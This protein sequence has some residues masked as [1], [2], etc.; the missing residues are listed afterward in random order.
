MKDSLLWDTTVIGSKGENAFWVSVRN[1]CSCVDVS[2]QI[3]SS[4]KPFV[5]K[6]LLNV[7]GGG[8]DG[9]FEVDKKPHLLDEYDVDMAASFMAGEADNYLP[10]VYC[11]YPARSC[12]RIDF[13]KLAFDLCGLAHVV[14]EPSRFFSKELTYKVFQRNVYGG[15]VGIYWPDGTGNRRFY[16]GTKYKDAAQLCSAVQSEVSEAHL[17]RLP[18]QKCTW[19]HLKETYSRSEVERLK[20][21]GSTELNEYIEAFSGENEALKA[22]NANLRKEVSRLKSELQWQQSVNNRD[23]CGLLAFGRE[24]ELY[25]GEFNDL[26]VKILSEKIK[27]LPEETRGYHILKSILDS[28]KEVGKRANIEEVIKRSVGGSKRLDTKAKSELETVGFEIS[29]DGKHYKLIFCGDARYS[30]TLPKTGSDYRSS[31]NS[32]SDIKKK[33]F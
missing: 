16:I 14:V 23:G 11:S 21:E 27:L 7:L 32:V 28:N 30:F 15:A 6:L 10:V 22:D 25:A 20:R 24:Q 18:M 26:L 4:K 2:T 5:I 12:E 19:E 17:K 3:Q 9:Q 13:E 31:R 8:V 29:E 1:S 33:L